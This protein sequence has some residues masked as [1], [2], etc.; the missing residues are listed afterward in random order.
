VSGDPRRQRCKGQSLGMDP[1]RVSISIPRTWTTSRRSR[2][3]GS[4]DPP[5]Q[6]TSASFVQGPSALPEGQLSG[7]AHQPNLT[8]LQKLLR[9]SSRARPLGTPRGEH[10]RKRAPDSGEMRGASA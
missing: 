4:Q 9:D 7:T 2:P 10:A 8:H 6:G 3:G 5:G 1:G